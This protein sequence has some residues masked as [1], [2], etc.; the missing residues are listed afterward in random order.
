[1]R[2]IAQWADG[3]AVEGALSYALAATALAMLAAMSAIIIARLGRVQKRLESLVGE[4]DRIVYENAALRRR[5]EALVGSDGPDLSTG[6]VH[7]TE[8][9]GIF[10]KLGACDSNESF[11]TKSSSTTVAPH[12]AAKYSVTNAPLMPGMQPD[13][14][15]VSMRARGEQLLMPPRRERRPRPPSV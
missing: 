14:L 4:K 7:R 5:L 12:V 9:G 1:M 8:E 2:L 13:A 10:T 3:S 11:T 6:G 15:D